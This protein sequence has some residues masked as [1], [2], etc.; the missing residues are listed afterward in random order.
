VVEAAR[1]AAHAGRVLAA[2]VCLFMAHL[3][4]E[5]RGDRV[6]SCACVMLNIRA[7]PGSGGKSKT[8]IPSV[9]TVWRASSL[10]A[11]T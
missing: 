10:V 4:G 5:T 1:Q 2:G 6:V 7:H 9:L 3:R 11:S 8:S